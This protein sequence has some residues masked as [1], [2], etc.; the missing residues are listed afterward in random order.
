MSAVR[1]VFFNSDAR[2]IVLL[3]VALYSLLKN[4]RSDEPLKVFIACDGEFTEAGCRE[5]LQ[6]IASGFPFAELVF[7]DFGPLLDLHAELFRSDHNQ[8]S[9]LLWA[10][11]LCTEILPE[12]VHGNL[13]YLD[14]DMLIR[15]DLEPLYGLP[16][17]AEGY[18]AA[19]VN[20]SRRETRP[21]MVESGWPEAAGYGF[22]NA[23]LVIDVDAYRRDGIPAKIL[24][25]YAKYKDVSIAVDQDAENIVFGDRTKRL[26]IRWNYSDGWLERILKCRPWQKE[27]RVHPR[28][29][30][31][32]A[33]FNPAIIHYVGG[34]KPTK[35]THRPERKVH[36]AMMRE[37]GL[38]K[39]RLPEGQGLPE[40]LEGAFFD[41]YHAL[42]RI[43]ARFLLFLFRNDR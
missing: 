41:C 26:P 28:K 33:I 37:L 40:M 10:F 38:M 34:R 16:L 30:V 13:V 7:I 23:T 35:R 43:Y 36:R 31:L 18:L 2:G 32:E 19:A 21:H 11:P 27:W 15:E 29:E 42:L 6:R 12:D 3:S 9:P 22:N 14:I 24:E 5:R 20:E 25:W 8:W 39:G 1:Q 17:A 4:S